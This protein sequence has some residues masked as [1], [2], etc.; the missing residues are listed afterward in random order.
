MWNAIASNTKTAGGER[1]PKLPLI[2][3]GAGWN[4]GGVGLARLQFWLQKADSSFVWGDGVLL[5]Y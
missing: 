4:G 5:T 1:Q 2:L 3:G